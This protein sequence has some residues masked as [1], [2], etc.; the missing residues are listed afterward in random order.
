MTNA[1]SLIDEIMAGLRQE[2]ERFVDHLRPCEETFDQAEAA[3]RRFAEA[4]GGLGLRSR[5]GCLLKAQAHGAVGPTVASPAG[6]VAYFERY[7]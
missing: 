7:E 6:G 1:N 5:V 4:C 3:S 2:V